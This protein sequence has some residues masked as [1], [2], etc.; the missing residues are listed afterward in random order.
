MNTDLI[1]A[2]WDNLHDQHDEV[3]NTF[4]DRFFSTYPAY[5]DLF[6]DAVDRHMK[7][8]INMVALVSRVANETEIT[9]SELEMLGAHHANFH[10]DKGDLINFKTTFLGVISEFSGSNWTNEHHQVWNEVF[11]NHVIPH[12]V[13]GIQAD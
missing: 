13:L 9:Q 3:I 4:F 10:L 8:M 2:T 5:K 12:M 6:P 7:K 11:D 1:G